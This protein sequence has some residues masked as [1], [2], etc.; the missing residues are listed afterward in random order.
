M[1]SFAEIFKW[2]QSESVQKPS[3]KDHSSTNGACIGMFIWRN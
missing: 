2:K 1:N 3:Q